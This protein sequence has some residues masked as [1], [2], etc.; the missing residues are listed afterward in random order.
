MECHACQ[1]ER[2]HRKRAIRCFQFGGRVGGQS[3]HPLHP[4]V[5]AEGVLI[6]E[7]NTTVTLYALLRAKEFALTRDQQLL[8]IQAED[9]PPAEHFASY[10]R[11]ELENEKKRWNKPQYN[12]RKTGGILSCL[13]VTRGVPYR[14]TK[15]GGTHFKEFAVHNGTFCT[16]D[17]FSLTAS[18]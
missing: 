15:G 3:Q 6:T 16:L 8:W 14:I 12:A 9:S 11:E 13:P 4:K 7:R 10:T 17:G 1:N 18:E 5:F 2:Q